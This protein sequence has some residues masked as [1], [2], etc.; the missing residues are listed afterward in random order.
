MTTDM[1]SI[2]CVNGTYRPYEFAN[3]LDEAVAKKS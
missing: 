3:L 2:G 1:I